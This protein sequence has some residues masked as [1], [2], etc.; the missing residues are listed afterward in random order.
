MKVSPKRFACAGVVS[1]AMLSTYQGPPQLAT[2][3]PAPLPPTPLAARSEE[4]PATG[5]AASAKTYTEAE[6][7]MAHTLGV[8][9]SLSGGPDGAS[10]GFGVTANGITNH[11]SVCRS[12]S[13]DFA[14]FVFT[15]L[16]GQ[17]DTVDF[18]MVSPSGGTV[19]R[20]TW[21]D[22]KILLLHLVHRRGKR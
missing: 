17:A 18:K 4:R 19:Y 8:G 22:Q 11:W 3:K 13:F 9:S 10:Y 14:I 21:T 15:S 1:L 16:D 2:F 6:I 12:C 20:Y 7:V 5:A